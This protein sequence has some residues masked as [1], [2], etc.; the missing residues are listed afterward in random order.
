[1]DRDPHGNVQV[2]KI[3]TEKLLA[4]MVEHELKLR[5]S[6]GTYKGSFNY[7]THYFGYEGRCCMPSNVDANYCYSL[8]RGAAALAARGAT[9]VMV[10]IAD[11]HLPPK[12]WKVGGAPLISLM[13]IEM[14]KGKPSAVIEK[15]LVRLDGPVMAALVKHRD[16]WTV[17]DRYRSPGP[18]QLY[19][20][21]ADEVNL[22]L[23]IEFGGYNYVSK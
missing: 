12:Q 6:Q 21:L 1:M 16:S 4:L 22:T 3:E 8:G 10:S 11:L 18:T 23:R 14:R 5:K 7:V 13:T 17:E 19:G 15:A 2:A 9:G 20:P